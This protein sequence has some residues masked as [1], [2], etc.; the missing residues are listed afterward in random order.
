METILLTQTKFVI[1]A[2]HNWQFFTRSIILILSLVSLHSY[3][4]NSR[5]LKKQTSVVPMF[6]V[7]MSG[8]PNY[9]DE[10]VIYYQTG[11]TN[12][13]D[14]A[15]D[16]YK[17]FGSNPAPHISIDNDSLLMVINGIPPVIQTYT[18]HILAT[19]PTTGNFTITAANIQGLPAGTCVFLKDLQ[20]NI[21][22]NLLLSPYSFNLSN[23]T[24]SSRF[25]LT[26]TY[27]TL[28]ITS[29]INQPVCLMPYSGKISVTGNSNSPWNYVWKD[30]LGTVIKTSFGINTSDT[31]YNVNGGS[32]NVEITSASNACLG[33]EISFNINEVIFPNVSFVSND[34]ITAGILNNFTPT[35]SSL[36]CTNYHWDFGDGVG[37]SF[38]FEPNYTYNMPGE[39]HVKIIGT[40]NTG[41]A[42]SSEKTITVVS[43]ATFI[44]EASGQSVKFMNMG[45]NNFQ[46][47][48]LSNNI[49]ELQIEVFDLTGKNQLTDRKENLKGIE[50]IFLNFNSLTQGTYLLSIK[51]KH[52]NL[53]VKKIIIN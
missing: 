36:N 13:F 37:S 23:T 19:T 20:T 15:Y 22:V 42:D 8:L 27:N 35:N 47:K 28:P 11:A 53:L 16:A 6:R 33:N 41:C 9:L 46:I 52:T 40:S 26:I 5:I 29:N 7:Q 31:L 39:Y 4:F 48:L 3:S 10:C 51:E 21:S 45:N 49:E 2:K 32:Y 44:N 14:N 43:L 24:T 25:I 1:Q 17:L 34:T 12:G 18:T 50:N 38:I 30:T